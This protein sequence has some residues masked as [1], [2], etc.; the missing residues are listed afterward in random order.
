MTRLTPSFPETA[1]L[2]N[3]LRRYGLRIWRRYTIFPETLED[4]LSQRRNLFSKRAIT[5]MRTTLVDETK[6]SRMRGHKD[7]KNNRESDPYYLILSAQSDVDYLFRNVI[8]Y[9]IDR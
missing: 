2:G 4:R 3:S 5:A 6:R 1:G 9:L 7:A 8:F